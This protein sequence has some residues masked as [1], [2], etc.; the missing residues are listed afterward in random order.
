MRPRAGSGTHAGTDAGAHAGRHTVRPR[1]PEDA[2]ALADLRVRS[3]RAAYRGLLPDDYLDRMPQGADEFRAARER[4][5]TPAARAGRPPVHHLVAERD[6]V[7]T[8][9]AVCGPE[10]DTGT[11]A[12]ELLALYV[13]PEHW[14]TGAGRTLLAAASEM[15]AADGHPSL[16]LWVLEGNTRARRFYE[17]N[18]LRPTGHRRTVTLGAPVPEVRYEAALC[19]PGGR[20]CEDEA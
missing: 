14:S 5:W 20:P 12:G 17:R 11:R 1:R 15:L 6:R 4:F 9:F 16:A 2:D 8:G 19:R 10:R 3:W 18:G 7:L 13:A